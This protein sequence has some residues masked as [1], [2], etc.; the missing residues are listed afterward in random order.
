MSVTQ[1]P[2]IDT[3]A[4]LDS[5]Q[6]DQDRQDVIQ[7]ALQ[8]G[9]T[10]MITIGCDLASSRASVELARQH[11]N[12]YAAVGIHPHDAA[13]LNE[14]ALENLKN[15]ADRNPKVVAIG[16]IGL[17]YYRDRCPRDIQVEAFRQQIRL[18]RSL[19]RPIIVHDRD[20]HQDVLDIMRE[21]KAA[22]V[23]GVLH[24]FSG[25]LAMA[26]ECMDMGFYLSF[27]G[28]ITYPKN[29]ALRDV[30]QAVPTDR[31]LIETD[32]P[33]LA[34]QALRG[35]R[36]EPALLRH[37]AE[38]MARI[39]GL[40]VEDIARVTNLNVYQLFGIGSVDLAT[41]IAYRIRNS[42][43]LN[44]T[45]RC[46][47]ACVFCAKFRD[48]AVKGHQLKLDHEP[49]VEEIKQAIGDPRNYEEIVFCGYGEPLLRLDVIREIGTWLHRQGVPVRINTDGQANL[50]YGR[51]ILPELGTFVD[52]ISISLN[53]ADAA[54]Y[55]KICQSCFGE[56][57]YQA[58]KDFIKEAKFHIPSVTASVVAMPGIDV[59]ACRHIVEQELKVNFR[60]RPYNEVG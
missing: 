54:T 55:Q 3:H 52:A 38:E 36:N 53:A 31:L 35:K 5:R 59:E 16:E 4:H 49:S 44:I 23:G 21:E 32:C 1:P 28:T 30:L 39:K 33:Y 8:S 19:G 29:Q 12:V 17:D 26:H 10:H 51:N 20:A 47:N 57:G 25:D 43:Y 24:C 22:E 37:T 27:P 42:L 45:N 6:Y 14:S 11:A 34:P 2:L 18:A 56:D 60:V 13:E 41:K 48:F 46:S 58:V 9:I 40:T 7:R 50:V 15:L